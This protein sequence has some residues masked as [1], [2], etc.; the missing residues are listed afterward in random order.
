MDNENTFLVVLFKNE[1]V[2]KVIN[3]NMCI[4][5]NDI[6]NIKRYET[7]KVRDSGVTKDVFI[8]NYFR[9]FLF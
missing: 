1:K 4:N 5:L 7:Y 6:T 3:A 9:K 8:L 2:K